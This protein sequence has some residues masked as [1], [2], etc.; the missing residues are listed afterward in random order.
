MGVGEYVMRKLTPK[1][2]KFADQYILTGN[3]RQ[4]AVYAGYS[5]KTASEIASENLNKPN[6]VAYIEKQLEEHELDVKL[7]QK[8]ILDYAV[9]V[10]TEQETEEH[11]FV[12][13]DG[14]EQSIATV[15]L[16]PKI[17]DKN[18]AAKFLSTLTATVEKNKLA[19]LKLLQEIEKLKAE[20]EKIS[21]EDGDNNPISIQI[22]DSWTDKNE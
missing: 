8:Q 1:Q 7:R 4:S 6:I 15:R 17:K 3:A 18:D 12:V 14:V 11:A 2:K 19:N 16:K 20:T 10:L 9:R 21:K 5:E 22:V 13:S